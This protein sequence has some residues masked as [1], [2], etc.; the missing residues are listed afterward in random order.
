MTSA[1]QLVIN[2]HQDPAIQAQEKEQRLQNAVFPDPAKKD[3]VAFLLGNLTPA[4][5]LNAKAFETIERYSHLFIDVIISSRFLEFSEWLKTNKN[6]KIASVSISMMKISWQ[7]NINVAASTI[8]QAH[9]SAAVDYGLSCIAS[10]NLSLS[11]QSCRMVEAIL[12]H[13]P[14]HSEYF[15]LLQNHSLLYEK[16]NG[17]LFLRYIALAESLLSSGNEAIARFIVDLGFPSML[18]KVCRDSNDLLLQI[19]A[20][21]L[22]PKLASTL[23]GLDEVCKENVFDWLIFSSCGDESGGKGPD[24]LLESE[25]LRTLGTLFLA[26]AKQSHQ[27]LL[28]IHA[29]SVECFLKAITRRLEEGDEVTKVTCKYH[30][31]CGF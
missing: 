14:I 27:F 25:A 31:L 29:K 28:K 30:L 8:P 9:L 24:P 3:L 6:E 20:M 13:P 1:F 2:I 11:E 5:E 18:C 22:L 21:D 15:M 7:L 23:I 16:T 10:S 4:E 19:T 12:S 26:A 17:M